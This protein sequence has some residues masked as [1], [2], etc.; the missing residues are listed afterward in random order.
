MLP[1]GG[2]EAKH[3]HSE[4]RATMP[5]RPCYKCGGTDH[6][7]ESCT[8][9]PGTLEHIDDFGLLP[10]RML[11]ERSQRILRKA[12]R[13]I[14]E[15]K[16][17]SFYWASTK[18]AATPPE[19]WETQEGK[20]YDIFL[21]RDFNVLMTR[22]VT[23]Q[24]A[25]K[26]ELLR[27]VRVYFG[28]VPPATEDEEAVDKANEKSAVRFAFLTSTEKMDEA[29]AEYIRDGAF[30]EPL[31]ERT[32]LRQPESTP[33]GAKRELFCRFVDDGLA[34]HPN[35]ERKDKIWNEFGDIFD[36]KGAKDLPQ[37]YVGIVTNMRPAECDPSLTVITHSQ[38]KFCEAL[39]R[40]F[41][42]LDESE[43][44]KGLKELKE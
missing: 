41:W 7:G 43:E 10:C 42:G 5:E 30:G 16:E 38:T 26:P 23:E 1:R 24:Q 2:L 14:E 20:V 4:Q 11:P 35:D 8:I 15:N 18:R 39:V 21:D 29:V 28:N 44:L 40:E 37:N 3:T 31:D 17:P 27:H 13:K 33:P 9:H 12:L 6:W 32:P 34:A 19:K 25:L 36:L 22:D